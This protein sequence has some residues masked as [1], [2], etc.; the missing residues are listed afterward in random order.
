M[1]AQT[2]KAVDEA[3]VLVFVVDA[4]E[5]LTA[6][7]REVATLLR[8][9]NKPVLLAANKVD[10]AKREATLGGPVRAGLR[11]AVRHLSV[12]RRGIGDLLD[13]LLVAARPG[14]AGGA[15]GRG[16]AAARP[17]RGQRARAKPSGR[18][19]HATARTTWRSGGAR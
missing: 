7:D 18:G 16:R 19:G 13:R 1:R 10:S 17:R 8:R 2:L 12:P 11:R 5:G 6:V 15:R 14:G 9:A 4:V 3:D